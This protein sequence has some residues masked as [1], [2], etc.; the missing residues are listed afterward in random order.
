[1]NDIVLMSINMTGIISGLHVLCCVLHVP[2]ISSTL[3]VQLGLHS[4]VDS[5]LGPLNGGLGEGAEDL[6]CYLHRLAEVPKQLGLHHTRMEGVHSHTTAYK[7][8][9]DHISLI[10][11][12]KWH[13]SEQIIKTVVVSIFFFCTSMIKNRIVLKETSL[14]ILI[15]SFINLHWIFPYK[16]CCSGTV[17]VQWWCLMFS[18]DVFLYHKKQ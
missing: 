11:I 16:K 17:V 10:R 13:T 9:N 8:N 14:L 18:L 2:V 5:G 6:D 7:H 1:M 15:Q 3:V 4:A 12:S